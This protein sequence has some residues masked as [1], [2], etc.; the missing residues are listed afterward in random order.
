MAKLC[1]RC[2]ID[3]VEADIGLTIGDIVV[4]RN[5][6]ENCLYRDVN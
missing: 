4:K 1:N 6:C 5:D 3:F 2:I